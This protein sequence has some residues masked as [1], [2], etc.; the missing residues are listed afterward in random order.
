MASCDMCG[1]DS[2]LFKT[3][4][5]GTLMKVCR[6]CSKFGRVLGEVKV[7]VRDSNKEKVATLHMP[8][9]EEVVEEVVKDYPQ[10]LLR[11][12]QKKKMDQQDFAR[13]VA[14][15]E[16]VISKLETGHLK[17]S[18]K[19]ARKLQNRLGVRL[20]QAVS[21]EKFELEKSAGKD[22]TLGDFIKIKKK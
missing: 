17:P 4:I 6:N 19:L 20:I 5:E 1:R 10:I 16:S 12:R 8:E 2:T 21:E 3:K 18:L 9:K 11:A 13:F 22:F 15:K 7:E 14:E